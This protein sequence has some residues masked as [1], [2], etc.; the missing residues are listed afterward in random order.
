MSGPRVAVIAGSY[1]DKPVI[2]KAVKVLKEFSV[3][4]EVF[5]YSAHRTPE[6]LVTLLKED[7]F[8][9]Y[10]AIAGLSAALPGVIAAH[11]TRPVIGVPVSGKVNMDSIL[12]IV[13]M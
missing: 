12:S 3:D 8:D 1:S 10:I 13:Q 6:E 5:I 2:E 9:C 7:N 11:T 4:Y